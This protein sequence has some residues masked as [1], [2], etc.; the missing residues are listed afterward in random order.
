MAAAVCS[1]Y[2]KYENTH[3]QY[4][5]TLQLGIDVTITDKKSLLP[6]INLNVTQNE[7]LLKKKTGGATEER[8]WKRRPKVTDLFWGTGNPFGHNFHTVLGSDLTYD[9][10][11]LPILISTMVALC[12]PVNE[13]EE[14]G[15]VILSYGKHR[16][17][18]PVFF[19]QASEHFEID[20]VPK[21][22][23]PPIKELLQRG[24]DFRFL[25]QIQQPTGIARMRL[26]VN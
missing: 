15:E 19:E 3:T 20:Q 17:A 26:K 4:R 16:A 13:G 7:E 8:E 10:D 11:I 12:K 1:E 6:L 2:I 14:P 23:I 18:I 5:N 22:E 9:M 24:A 25:K 21:E